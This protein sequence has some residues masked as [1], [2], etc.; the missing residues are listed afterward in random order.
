[1]AGNERKRSRAKSNELPKRYR[2]RD[3]YNR[4]LEAQ[5]NSFVTNDDSGSGSQEARGKGVGVGGREL[6][7][8]SR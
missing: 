2:C 6:E 4:A 3:K 8:G 7:S 1:M 5:M